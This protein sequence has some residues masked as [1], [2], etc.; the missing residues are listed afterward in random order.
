[1]KKVLLTLLLFATS[2]AMA[3]T[4]YQGT[5]G[6]YANG[7]LSIGGGV[8]YTTNNIGYGYTGQTIG[9]IPYEGQN[10]PFGSQCCSCNGC[11][12]C[13]NSYGCGR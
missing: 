4:L 5:V 10:Y 1:M 6:G 8:G 11:N 9:G 7:G 2:G 13:G 12:P 3:D